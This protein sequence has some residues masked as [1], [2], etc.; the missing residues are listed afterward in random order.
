[1][2]TTTKRAGQTA[3][4]P[5]VRRQNELRQLLE[6]RRREILATLHD[7]MKGVRAEGSTLVSAGVLDEEEASE[8]DVQEDIELALIEMKAET[9]RRIDEALRRLDA[10]LYGRCD[11]C[12]EDIA[13]ARL[14]AL[15]FAVRCRDC[16]ELHETD[17]ARARTADDRQTARHGYPD[18]FDPTASRNER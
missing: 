10:G 1:M 2:A 13:H 8:A 15:P 5:E 9:L 16:E 3:T 18:R 6:D 17:R 4:T 14:R 11:S 7:R 12:G